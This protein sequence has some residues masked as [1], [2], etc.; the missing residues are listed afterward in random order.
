MEKGKIDVVLGVSLGDEAKGKIA[1]YL[2]D[3]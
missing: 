2:L 1:D 3:R